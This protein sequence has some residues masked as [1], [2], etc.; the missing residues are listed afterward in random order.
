MRHSGASHLLTGGLDEGHKDGGWATAVALV[1]L[2]AQRCSR[3]C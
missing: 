2:V 3:T 1:P